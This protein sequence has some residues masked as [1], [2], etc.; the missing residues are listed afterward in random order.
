MLTEKSWFYDIFL[1][2]FFISLFFAAWLG[3]HH[4]LIPDEGRYAE[5]IREMLVTHDYLTPRVDGVAFLEKPILF[6]WLAAFPAKLLGLNEWTI[7]IWPALCGV[8]GC[9]MTYS[10]ARI[11]FDRRTG[12]LA[13]V[14]LATC[15]LYFSMAHYV[16]FDLT[17]G[18]FIS[19]AL[20]S[21]I[22]AMKY[23]E[24]DKKIFLYA[25]YVFAGLAVLTKG[26]IGII[27]PAMI[28]GMWILIL[29]RWKILKEMHLPLGLLIIFAI[30]AP[31]FFIE[32]HA[33]PRFFE[34]FFLKNQFTRFLTANFNN[35]KPLW[36]YIPVVLIGIF[37]WLGFLFQS[38][39]ESVKLI[40]KNKQDRA[41]EL[42][43]LLWPLLIF[44]FFTIPSSKLIGYMI[45]VIPPLAILIAHYLSQRWNQIQS[46]E[47]Q[48]GAL[49]F[50]ISAIVIF[51]VLIGNFFIPH[52]PQAKPYFDFIAI[53]FLLSAIILLFLFR[54]AKVSKIVGLIASVSMLVL[55][56]VAA[57]IPTVNARSSKPLAMIV[58][59]LSK[60]GDLVVNYHNYS[61]DLPFYLNQ[62]VAVVADWNDP[63]LPM[64]DNWQNQ[65]WQ[66]MQFDGKKPWIMNDA[67]FWKEWKSHQRVFVIAPLRYYSILK[68]LTGNQLYLLSQTDQLVLVSNQK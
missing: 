5:A 6:Y 24:K 20:L 51:V 26:L 48:I 54:K 60:P 47:I 11:L 28:I 22:V 3:S 2:F 18:V 63:T 61:Q 29:N 49:F 36:F 38:I 43:L 15:P 1:L 66:G 13:A 62:Y 40:W 46:T 25:A 39:S 68:L 10:A 23:R 57:A 67:E 52:L 41:I 16:N 55:L 42:F 9:V 50:L 45:P 59:Q 34:F 8:L 17:V 12:I 44:L 37:P 33:E 53:I 14:I 32:Q 21:F 58:N 4:L 19:G 56:M 27:F 31:W 7:R 65:F 35:Q 30:N 64:N